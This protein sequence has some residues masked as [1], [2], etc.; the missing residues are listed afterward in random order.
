MK[1]ILTSIFILVIFSFLLLG[2]NSS[3][4]QLEN[5]QW[6]FNIQ[7]F[8]YL[9]ILLP[10]I[11]LANILSWHLIVSIF[12]KGIKFKENF[13]IWVYSN[14]SRLIP[15]SFWQY[16]SR[17]YLLSQSG[18]PKEVGTIAVIMEGFFN[19]GVGG[20]IV[21]L[22]SLFWSVP[23]SQNAR[24]FTIFFALTPI[25]FFLLL[26]VNFI[27][28]VAK[29]YPKLFKKITE[30][31]TSQISLKQFLLLFSMFSL[32]YIFAGIVF[33]IISSFFVSLSLESLPIWIAI[34]T[35]SWLAGYLTFFAPGGIGVVEASISGLLSF[36]IPLGL[37]ISIALVL[38]ALLLLTEFIFLLMILIF[39]KKKP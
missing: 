16:P 5:T 9:V 18:V 17:V 22:G 38:R 34:Y 14:A 27:S 10:L 35:F 26:K 8:I 12:N 15:G 39:L 23:V 11:F 33:F 3:W 19:L 25:I 21:L 1:K 29:Y 24:L 7:N 30:V 13:R 2:L 4:K 6:N 36:F 20:V 32:Q 31:D 37:A 28:K